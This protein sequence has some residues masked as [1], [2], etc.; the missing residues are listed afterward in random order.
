MPESC[1][2]NLCVNCGVWILFNESAG[3][4]IYHWLLKRSL[5]RKPGLSSFGKNPGMVTDEP[6][7]R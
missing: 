6:Y 4:G 5:N 1:K 3:F 7:S 2:E